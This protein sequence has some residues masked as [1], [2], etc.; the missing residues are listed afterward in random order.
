MSEFHVGKRW[1]GADWASEQTDIL[2]VGCG[3][4]GKFIW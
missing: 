3:G 1:G 2:I 4:I